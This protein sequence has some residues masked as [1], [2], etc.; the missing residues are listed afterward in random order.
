[1]AGAAIRRH[2]CTSGGSPSDLRSVV[3]SE[4]GAGGRPTQ[5]VPGAANNF[6]T[7]ISDR[8]A[9][10]IS[11]GYSRSSVMPNVEMEQLEA[12]KK[13]RAAPR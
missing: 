13:Q 4:H 2:I 7:S 11:S 9:P 6:M 12:R 10:R 3:R 5:T 8:A 1:M